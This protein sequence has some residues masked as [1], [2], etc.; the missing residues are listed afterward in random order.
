MLYCIPVHLNGTI[1]SKTRIVLFPMAQLPLPGIEELRLA[2]RMGR[3]LMQSAFVFSFFVNLLMLTGP[4]FML[5]IYDRVL[6]S[7]SVETL[8]ALFLL[9]SF[10]FALM[11]LLEY[12]RGRLMARVG[13]RF[14][15]TLD[16]R[17]FDATLRGTASGAPS[18]ALRNI[19]SIVALYVSPVLLA[20]MDMPWTP[21]FI[22]AIFIF[23]PMLGWAAL[24]GALILIVLALANQMLTANKVK[25]AQALGQAA[26]AFADQTRT[27]REV[28]LTQGMGDAM[29]GRWGAHRR[30]A[31]EKT[32]SANDWTGSFT[33]LTKTFRL[34][35]QSAMLALGAF[36][37]MR[38]EMSSG[39]MVAS[40]I[41]LGRALAPIEQALGQWPVIQR[42]RSGWVALGDYLA[43][44]PHRQTRL[45]LP[46]P[47]AALSVRTLAVAA[48]GSRLPT[49]RNITFNLEPG[50]A[51]GVI[52]NSGSGK[53]TLA[54][55]LLGYWPALAGE[56]RLGG[57]TLD[58]YNPEQL[59]RHIGYLPQ[60]VTL[61][62]GTVA[63]NIARMAT[64][65]D[66]EAVV[67]AA[68]RANA[69]E[70]ITKLPQGY[71]TRLDANESQLSGGQRQ[72]IALA[73]ALYGD[74]VLLI[75]DEPNS[76]LDSN[77]STALNLTVRAFKD[78]RRSVIIMTHRPMAI[79]EC[80]LLMVMENGSVTALGPRDSVLRKELQNAE[81]VRKTLKQSAAE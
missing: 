26:Q 41:M 79:A 15:Q 12:A 19:D 58:Q 10:L 60:T 53:S 8:S 33:S 61:F 6:T 22:A 72:R 68:K 37:V 7:R 57:A 42:A 51:L 64:K 46:T 35:L 76:A 28:V 18:S 32:V 69:H 5:Q 11:A 9:V 34:Y 50:Q 67:S 52:G 73:R 40:S 36:L 38:G 44:I 43:Q 49:L 3:R 54:R 1:V 17:V 13:G 39:A 62:Q 21:L 59:G 48:P 81:T 65:P 66:A 23:H 74:P 30:E 14:Q 27:G 24:A 77:G 55:A 29:T 75:L 25:K 47:E 16:Q 70:M 31:L 4:L 78:S 56:I 45:E 80:D 63:E 20:V 71:N 2:R